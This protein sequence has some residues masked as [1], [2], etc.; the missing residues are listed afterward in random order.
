MYY[1]MWNLSSLARDQASTPCIG[2]VDG[3]LT[4]EL[5]GKSQCVE[6]HAFEQKGEPG[7]QAMRM[8]YKA[9][10]YTVGVQDGGPGT[11]ASSDAGAKAIHR[12]CR[13]QT[14]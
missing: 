8:A 2:N 7:G 11:S 5:L 13:E 14:E 6:R 10:A 9:R 4:T 3:I 12:D 1:S